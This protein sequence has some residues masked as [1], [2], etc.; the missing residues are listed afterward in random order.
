VGR[1]GLISAWQV[2]R[3][4]ALLIV[5]VVT[6]DE[7]APPILISRNTVESATA[8]GAYCSSDTGRGAAAWNNAYPAE[9]Y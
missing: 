8:I 6:G 2:S 9:I 3:Y 4:G 7:K 1:K 5:L